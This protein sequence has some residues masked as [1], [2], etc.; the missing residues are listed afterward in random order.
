[1]PRTKEAIANMAERRPLVAQMYIR[2]QKAPTIH[3]ALLGQGFICDLAT[4]YRDIKAIEAEWYKVLVEDPVAVKA[5]ELEEYE[6]AEAECWLQYTATRQTRWLTELRGWKERK[7]KLLGLDAPVSVKA[8]VNLTHDDPKQ[9]LNDRIAALAARSGADGG[10][11]L[12][13]E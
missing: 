4:V 11:R 5:K 9:A 13:I 10:T 12:P 7:A 6:A 3:R 8:D 2:H 1:M